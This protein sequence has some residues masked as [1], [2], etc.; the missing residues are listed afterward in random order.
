MRLEVLQEVVDAYFGD[1][2]AN[3]GDWLEREVEAI[4]GKKVKVA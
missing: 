1:G 4:T 3:F 2:I